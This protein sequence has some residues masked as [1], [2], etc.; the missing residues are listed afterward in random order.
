MAVKLKGVDVSHH[1]G[2]IDWQ[3]VAKT[4]I[5]FAIIRACYGWDNDEQIDKRFVSNAAGC[6]KNNIPYGFYHYSYAQTPED[7]K[8]EAAFFLRVIKGYKPTYPVYFDFEEPSQVGGTKNGKTYKGLPL[9]TQL[10]IIEAFLGVIEAAGYYGG[11]YMSASHLERLYKYSPYRVGKYATWVAHINT[12][13]PAYSGNYGMW[14]YS[15]KGHVDGSSA[16]TDVNWAYIDYPSVIKK[17][18]LNGWKAAKP[19]QTPAQD[20]EPAEGKTIPLET[21]NALQAKYDALQTKYKA[22]ISAI[23]EL[24]AKYG[25]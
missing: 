16:E 10:Q 15:W 24:M 1:N 14:Q 17:A 19:E 4:G 18:G 6:E 8:K 9:E 11:L 25:Q 7:A 12:D 21:Y 13:K 20:K 3:K 5:R 22:V 2:A 23:K